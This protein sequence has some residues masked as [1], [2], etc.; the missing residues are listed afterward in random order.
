[1]KTLEIEKELAEILQSHDVKEICKSYY[2]RPS[3][4]CKQFLFDPKGVE[5]ICSWKDDSLN[6]FI[7]I[8]RLIVLKNTYNQKT[9]F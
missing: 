8:D 4:V 7:P 9:L 6:L 2:G 5:C 3:I 1:M